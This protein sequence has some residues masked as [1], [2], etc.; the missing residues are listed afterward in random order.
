MGPRASAI[1]H[2]EGDVVP[3]ASEGDAAAEDN[4]QFRRLVGAGLAPRILPPAVLR[5]GH[6]ACAEDKR[7]RDVNEEVLAA[8]IKVVD[9]D[10]KGAQASVADEVSL[11]GDYVAGVEGGVCNQE[12]SNGVPNLGFS[13]CISE[14]FAWAEYEYLL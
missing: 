11:F 2:D 14:A 5:G 8:A 4:L 3:L 1:L 9:E 10:V 7:A 12:V 6:V 13:S